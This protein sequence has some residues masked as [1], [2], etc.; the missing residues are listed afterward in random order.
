M[1]GG[2]KSRGLAGA[3]GSRFATP[4]LRFLAGGSCWKVGAVSRARGFSAAK[5]TLDTAPTF[6]RMSLE[7]EGKKT[8][9]CRGVIEVSGS[10]QVDRRWRPIVEALMQAL[11]VVELDVAGDPG[12]RLRHRSVI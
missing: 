1:L 4:S 9:K 3:P 6:H 12:S 5:R 2:G 8:L 10:S 11:V 7:S